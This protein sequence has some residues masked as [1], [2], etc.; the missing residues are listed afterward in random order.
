MVSSCFS[1]SACFTLARVPA[2]LPLEGRQVFHPEGTPPPT[3]PK[4][5]RGAGGGDVWLHTSHCLLLIS[6]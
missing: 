6:F 4:D 5:L 2:A 1:Q 3:L